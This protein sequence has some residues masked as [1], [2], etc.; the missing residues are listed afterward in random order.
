MN[1]RIKKK[2]QNKKFK[3]PKYIVRLAK[4][5]STMDTNIICGYIYYKPPT[6]KSIINSK[7][8]KR[9]IEKFLK[10]LN[11]FPY[12]YFGFK[13]DNTYDGDYQQEGEYRFQMDYDFDIYN[14]IVGTYYYP[15]GNGLYLCCN[16]YYDWSV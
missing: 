15:V 3:I 11:N 10:E 9:R 2:L 6:R 16:Y 7:R 5:W 1:K 14:E 13:I 12:E 4:R 8:K